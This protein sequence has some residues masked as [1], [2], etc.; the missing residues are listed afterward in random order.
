MAASMLPRWLAGAG[1]VASKGGGRGGRLFNGS[2]DVMSIEYSRQSASPLELASALVRVSAPAMEAPVQRLP[3][4]AERCAAPGASCSGRSVPSAAGL[5]HASSLASRR[6]AV[7]L[8][9]S[10][11]RTGSCRG[12]RRS[13]GTA[14]AVLAAPRVTCAALVGA[15]ATSDVVAMTPDGTVRATAGQPP[16]LP[17]QPRRVAWPVR[18]SPLCLWLGH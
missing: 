5:R 4:C 17:A 3:R 16:A 10:L 11:Q 18:S 7:S 2:D 12:R 6:A 8:G 13:G 1:E 9:V 15:A 14:G